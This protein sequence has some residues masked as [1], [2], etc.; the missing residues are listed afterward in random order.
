MP[1]GGI[2]PPTPVLGP[3]SALGSRP[4]VALS[5]ARAPPV[6]SGPRPSG[7]S[8]ISRLPARRGGGVRPGWRLGR[9]DVHGP[10]P[11]GGSSWCGV[12]CNA[13]YDH[14]ILSVL[15]GGITRDWIA[16]SEATDLSCHLSQ[17]LPSRPSRSAQRSTEGHGQ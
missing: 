8:G 17:T 11:T 9:E 14:H 12:R 2:L 4:R 16:S 15:P 13:S 1:R 3:G 10:A 5:S 6:Y 7:N